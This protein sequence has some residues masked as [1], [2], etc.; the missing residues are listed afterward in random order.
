MS[1]TPK[2]TLERTKPVYWPSFN[3]SRGRNVKCLRT[4]IPTDHSSH[5]YGLWLLTVV[6][7]HVLLALLLCAPIPGR[8][9]QEWREKYCTPPPPETIAVIEHKQQC[10]PKTHPMWPQNQFNIPHPVS[11]LIWT[12][13]Q[14]QV[15]RR[16]TRKRHHLKRFAFFKIVDAYSLV[17][18]LPLPWE[19]TWESPMHKSFLKFLFCLPRGKSVSLGND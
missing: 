16:W 2:Y 18:T 11:K 9:A 7:C 12:S 13:G 1:L 3:N 5:V 6:H 19:N 14:V 17:N 10:S 4:R 8:L 15:R